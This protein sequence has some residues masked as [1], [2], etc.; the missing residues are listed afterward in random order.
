[1]HENPVHVK[2]LTPQPIP[3]GKPLWKETL[4]SDDKKRYQD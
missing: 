3:S 2:I 1:L 4:V